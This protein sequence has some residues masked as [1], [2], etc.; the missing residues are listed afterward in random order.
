[1]ACPPESAAERIGRVSGPS[2][3]LARDN[4]SMPTVLIKLPGGGGVVRRDDGQIV[5]THDV[6][7]DQGQPVRGGDDY[8]P[9]QTWLDEARSGCLQEPQLRG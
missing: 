3:A 8:R 7:N 2:V 6:T 5:I 9:V 1:M 4:F